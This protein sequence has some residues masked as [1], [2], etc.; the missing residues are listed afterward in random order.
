[1]VKFKSSAGS[2]SYFLNRV[3]RIQSGVSISAFIYNV[4][5]I[6]VCTV[7]SEQ[8]QER[9]QTQQEHHLVISERNIVKTSTNSIFSNEDITFMMFGGKV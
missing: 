8:V 1:M 4:L 7:K 9:F 5:N 6:T 3:V 2:T